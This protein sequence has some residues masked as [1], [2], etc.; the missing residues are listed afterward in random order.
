MIS[1]SIALK[2]SRCEVSFLEKDLVRLF[3]LGIFD[4]IESESKIAILLAAR[5][6]D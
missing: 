1:T 5:S 2:K 3:L 6:S 4:E